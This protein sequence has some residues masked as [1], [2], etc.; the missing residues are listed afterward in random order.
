MA[1]V[2]YCQDYAYWAQV[3]VTSSCLMPLEPTDHAYSRA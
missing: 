3:I 2:F 1:K